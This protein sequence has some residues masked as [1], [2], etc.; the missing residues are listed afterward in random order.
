MPN[1]SLAEKMEAARLLIFNSTDPE[2]APLLDAYGID[3]PYLLERMTLYNTTAELIQK[4]IQEY[5]ESD[6][7]YDE[8]YVAKDEVQEAVAR[9]VKLVRV[10]SRND[11]DLQNRLNLHTAF[12][13]S[14]ADWI[15]HTITFYTLLQG[16]TEFVTTLNRFKLTTE[17][18]Q[19]EK[20]MVH[21]LKQLR[22]K[23]TVEN[24][25]AQE[26]TRERNEKLDQ[27]D[28]YCTELKVI[29]RLALESKPQLLEK[30]GVMV[31]N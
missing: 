10:L 8:F 28:D 21:N 5:R 1:Q 18:I 20:D 16:E 9:T 12:P 17:K 13:D 15:E 30:L 24:G 6:L 25:Q 7:A 29:A 23:V 19:Q 27:L 26:A 11:A 22:E 31:R 14:I 3:E 4:Q 2:V